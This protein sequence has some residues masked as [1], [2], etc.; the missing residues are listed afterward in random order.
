[1]S[2]RALAVT[3]AFLLA[4]CAGAA[5]LLL[6]RLGY[7]REPE[8]AGWAFENP[9]LGYAR[10]QR[11]VVRPILEGG[12]ALRYTFLVAVGEPLPEDPVAPLPHL[13]AGVEEREGED[14]F[15]RATGPVASLSLCQLGALTTQE[16]LTE[17]RPVREVSP[18][19]EDRILMQAT[20]GHQ[21]GSVVVYYHD[22]GR[23]V[24]CV[25]WERSEMYAKGRDPEVYF[26]SDGGRVELTG[27][28]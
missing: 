1:M 14:W 15:Y 25:G 8:A 13:R 16:W 20:Y 5:W 4:L 11:V 22:P 6:D 26:A 24:P 10:G 7:G 17:I 12:R 21:N 2:L 3:A 28:K 9:T 19:G 23:P 27:P 18:T